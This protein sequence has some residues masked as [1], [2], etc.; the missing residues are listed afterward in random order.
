MAANMEVPKLMEY[1]IPIWSQ[2]QFNG[3]LNITSY[4]E[5]VENIENLPRAP[6]DQPNTLDIYAFES[7]LEEADEII[8]ELQAKGYRPT[9]R[10]LNKEV[11]SILYPEY[12][13]KHHKRKREIATRRS[14]IMGTIV[15]ITRGYVATKKWLTL[16]P[17]P[18]AVPLGV[19]Q[20]MISFS[21]ANFIEYF[22]REF[23]GGVMYSLFKRTGFQLAVNTLVKT[24]SVL[25]GAMGS[26]THTVV[27]KAAENALLNTAMTSL[28]RSPYESIRA[29][30]FGPQASD[31]QSKER[32]E[33]LTRASE[34]SRFLTVLAMTPFQAIH[35][36]GDS[37]I[38]NFQA[39]NSQFPMLSISNDKLPWIYFGIFVASSVANLT[40]KE[41]LIKTFKSMESLPKRYIKFS[42]KR[43][44][45]FACQSRLFQLPSFQQLRISI[46]LSQQ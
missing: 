14:S 46:L 33:D 44:K 32:Q 30:L 10:V 8:N 18:I 27:Q 31:G 42:K 35:L 11:Q 22:D 6:E 21:R 9:L 13:T 1:R 4:H 3:T 12:I 40:L 23:K 5:E 24:V 19:L 26:I 37:L 16:I 7:D 25:S 20:A 17:A 43:L 34:W 45:D 28:G 41:F 36:T 2:S 39:L 38:L 15:A 29:R